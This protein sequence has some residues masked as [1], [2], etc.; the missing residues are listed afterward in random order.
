MTIYTGWDVQVGGFDG[1][2]SVTTSGTPT[3]ADDFTSRIRSVTVDHQVWLGR[4]GRSTATVVLDNQ[5]GALTPGGGGTHSSRDWFTEPLFV[6]ARADTSDPPALLTTTLNLRAPFFAGPIIEV[7][8]VDDGF[9]STLTLTAADWVT[10]VARF[11]AQT[12]STETA[13]VLTVFGNLA[14][15]VVRATFGADTTIPSWLSSGT[16]FEDVS[17]TVDA[18]DFIGDH[19]ELLAATEYG[20]IF[21]GNLVFAVSGSTKQ[22]FYLATGIQRAKLAPTT[23]SPLWTMPDFDDADSL[24]TTEL[25]YRELRLGFD[26]DRIVTQAS[27]TRSG[28]TAQTSFVDANS[29]KWGPRSLS[30]FGLPLTA[31]AD[32]SRMAS[33]LTT[34]FA[35]APLTVQGFEVT[36]SMI[37]DKAND[38]A[39]A[40]VQ[41][42]MHA[43]SYAF[44]A[45]WKPCTVKWAGTGG[46]TNEKDVGISRVQVSAGPDDW[47]MRFDT[48]DAGTNMGFVLDS[49]QLGILDQNRIT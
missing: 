49:D 28:G 39:L 9:D 22:V 42:L 1:T 48:F 24:A 34:R 14:S 7:D 30:Y 25:P 29:Q 33:F 17:L 21:P 44:G 46:T 47:T 41:T 10:F 13:E 45:L 40:G 4:V 16:G 37:E 15:D 32:S 36:G 5:D 31:D 3:D 26:V 23:S 43:P 19:Y 27:I 20:V 8:F 6:L 38:A 12:G 11:T 18:G 2:A 35:E